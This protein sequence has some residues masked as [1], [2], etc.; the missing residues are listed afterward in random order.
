MRPPLDLTTWNH[1]Y[2]IINPLQGSRVIETVLEAYCN[3]MRFLSPL[4][5]IWIQ[6]V[7]KT[8]F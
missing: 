6:N 7:P 3:Y 8:S 5:G 4:K 2:N 1:D